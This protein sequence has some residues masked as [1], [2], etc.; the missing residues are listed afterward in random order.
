MI[1]E[2]TFVLE[3]IPQVTTVNFP[4]NI[5][6]ILFASLK[7]F[8]QGFPSRFSGSDVVLPMLGVQ[9][10]TLVGELRFY[11]LCSVAKIKNIYQF[12]VVYLI[13]AESC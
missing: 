12:V 1:Q 11:L 5:T 10:H 4:L 9:V 3:N 2:F 8:Y 13:F 6:W 7:Q